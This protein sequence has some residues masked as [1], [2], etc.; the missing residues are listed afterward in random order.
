MLALARLAETQYA[1]QVVRSV[2][3]NW[4]DPLIAQPPDHPP[5]G[6]KSYTLQV[7]IVEGNLLSSF[8][9]L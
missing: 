3:E 1:R 7:Q 6:G 8:F 2:G 9:V 4:N 5:N